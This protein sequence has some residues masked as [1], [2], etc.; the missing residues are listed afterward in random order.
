[1]Y[2]IRE[3]NVNQAFL[4]GLALLR[5]GKRRESRNGPV[6]KMD[7]PVTTLYEKPRERV[8]FHEKRDANPFFHL[9]E[10]LWM[11]A[12]RNDLA[13]LVWYVKRMESFSD[14]GEVL[15]GAYGHR[16][17]HHW[18]FDQ[19][20]QIIVNLRD[21]PDDRRCVL[22]MFDPA[23]DLKP[24]MDMK[25]GGP[26]TWKDVPCNLVAKFAINFQGALNMTVFCRSNDIV[27]G[28]YGAN[29]VHFSVL[30][31][32]MAAG[33]GCEVGWYWQ[34]SDDWHGYLKT[35]APLM[36]VSLG[37]VL[38]SDPYERGEVE[39]YPMVQDFEGW[40]DDLSDFMHLVANP[41]ILEEP[42]AWAFRNPFFTEVAVP[43]HRAYAAHKRRDYA[44]ALGH[45][46]EVR[47]EDWR[48][49]ARRWMSLRTK[50]WAEREAS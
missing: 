28:C 17:R 7:C 42:R 38:G 6:L 45:V 23:V 21:N 8:L 16:W 27:W 10:S 32:Y 15:R 35:V 29:A 40:Y 46:D 11:L 19:L 3:R 48:L 26:V 14:D 39:P 24:A 18:E 33:I 25:R 41:W 31:E 49:D 43:M 44:T 20:N 37:E 9:F 5:N 36:D 50:R 4:A 12:G 30:Q 34:I 22:S 2:V 1:M 47:A 13:P